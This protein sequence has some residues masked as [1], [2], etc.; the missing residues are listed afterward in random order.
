MPSSS[1]PEDKPELQLIRDS[2]DI[3]EEIVKGKRTQL[4]STV[5]GSVKVF[6][7]SE[8]EDYMYVR[9]PPVPLQDLIYLQSMDE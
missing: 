1:E 6:V 9:T 8:D 4:K 5:V 3:E 2:S 7:G